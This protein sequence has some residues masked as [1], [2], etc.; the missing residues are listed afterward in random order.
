MCIFH[1]YLLNVTIIIIVIYTRLNVKKNVQ[2]E[3][4]FLK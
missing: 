3:L 1:K 2:I 4:I